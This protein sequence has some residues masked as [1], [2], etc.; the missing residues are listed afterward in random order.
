MCSA[1]P[2]TNFDYQIIK[3]IYFST[4][5]WKSVRKCT[6]SDVALPIT[7]IMD[8]RQKMLVNVTLECNLRN[9]PG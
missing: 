8:V 6:A 7:A 1:K 3:H 5:I 4:V 9:L 2:L